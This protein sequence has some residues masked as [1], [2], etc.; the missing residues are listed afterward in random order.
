MNNSKNIKDNAVNN[1][2]VEL[3]E[4]TKKILGK[5]ELVQQ[6]INDI[7]ACK[8]AFGKEFK[9]LESIVEQL[10]IKINGYE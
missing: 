10:N 9:H 2:K 6:Q 5:I 3:L 7:C 1:K 4:V 8:D